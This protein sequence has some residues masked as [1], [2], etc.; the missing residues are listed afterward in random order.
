MSATRKKK[1]RVL[2][3]LPPP[4][5]RNRIAAAL[6]ARRSS[7]TAGRHDRSQGAQRRAERVALQKAVRHGQNA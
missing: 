4:A 5:P 1:P 2:L 7:G 6:A 3:Q